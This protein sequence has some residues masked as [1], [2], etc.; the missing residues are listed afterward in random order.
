MFQWTLSVHRLH[1]AQDLVSLLE[2]NMDVAFNEFVRSYLAHPNLHPNLDW[3]QPHKIAIRL[4][5]NMKIYVGRCMELDVSRAARGETRVA[6]PQCRTLYPAPRTPASGHR[7]RDRS[8][9]SRLFEGPVPAA[10]LSSPAPGSQ[11][12]DR[13]TLIA[14][15]PTLLT[16]RNLHRRA[17]CP[18]STSR[19]FSPISMGGG[20]SIYLPVL[21]LTSRIFA[22]RARPFPFVRFTITIFTCPATA[23]AAA[24]TPF[25]ALVLGEMRMG[26]PEAK[27]EVCVDAAGW[28]ASQ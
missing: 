21:M 24:H 14:R 18:M 26:T 28:D 10:P 12:E 3:L 13:T 6:L 19:R 7:P 23:C 1:F 8:R 5:E 22:T 9:A 27:T 16:A 17:S 4:V 15:Y 11:A 20:A 2:R 25:L